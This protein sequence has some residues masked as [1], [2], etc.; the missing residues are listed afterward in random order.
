MPACRQRRPPSGRPIESAD[1]TDH[2]RQRRKRRGKCQ[3]R[4]SESERNLWH[5]TEERIARTRATL[6]TVLNPKRKFCR[7]LSASSATAKALRRLPKSANLHI[8]F[9]LCWNSTLQKVGGKASVKTAAIR[10]Q[11]TVDRRG[12]EEGS[13][14][15]VGPGRRPYAEV[16]ALAFA[17]VEGRAANKT[18]SLLFGGTSH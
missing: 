12:R 2:R 3:V 5:Q 17:S 14:P 9:L 1:A 7:D 11:R 8:L 4:R 10:H 13:Q 6:E 15:I 16:T 18:V